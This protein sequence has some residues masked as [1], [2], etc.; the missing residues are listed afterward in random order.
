[1]TL[2]EEDSV[3]ILHTCTLVSVLNWEASNKILNKMQHPEFS[4][5]AT[6]HKRHICHQ[7]WLI[8]TGL[9]YNIDL[10]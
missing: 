2:A 4:S 6:H 5:V 7:Y 8:Y 9:L 3:Y 1:M 10:M